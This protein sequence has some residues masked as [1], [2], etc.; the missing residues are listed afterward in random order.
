MRMAIVLG[1]TLALASGC[2]QSLRPPQ[3]VARGELTIS[4][5]R[6][7]V[8]REQGRVVAYGPV[9]RGLPRYVGC[10]E[11]A[12]RYAVGARHAGRAG[13]A[14]SII[15]AALGVGGL[16]ALGAFADREHRAAYALSGIGSG[17]L[18]LGFVT[19]GLRR[20]R[21][22][23]GRAIDAANEY[24]DAVGSL[25]ATCLDLR[26]APPSGPA[27]PMPYPAPTGP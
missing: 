1:L 26:F 18:G 25:G 24:N 14:L 20:K 19:G 27:S 2:P 3:I 9:F 6:T 5:E 4:M 12:R 17:M 21:V 23:F 15:G 11:P 8:L 10:V 13:R 7:V 22:A 16:V